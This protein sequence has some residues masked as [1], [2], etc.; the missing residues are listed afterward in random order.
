LKSALLYAVS[1]AWKGHT[2]CDP[3][4]LA[5]PNAR[6][7]RDAVAVG[8]GMT[9]TIDKVREFHAAFGVTDAASPHPCTA[10]IRELRVR[11]IAEELCELCDALGVALALTTAGPPGGSFVARAYAADE[12]VD[13]VE[14]ADALGDLDYVVQGANLVFGIPAGAVMDEIHRS[15]MSKLSDDG[16]PVLRPDGKITKGPKYT[17]PDIAKVLSNV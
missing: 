10:E 5:T 2:S 16:K 15:N 8:A 1:A 4:R 12:D 14:T 7:C 17:P 6:E 3:D 9:S 13:L 11:L